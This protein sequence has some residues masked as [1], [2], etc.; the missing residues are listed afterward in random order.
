MLILDKHPCISSGVEEFLAGD[1]AYDPTRMCL[2][3]AEIDI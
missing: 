2:D 3:I 1:F